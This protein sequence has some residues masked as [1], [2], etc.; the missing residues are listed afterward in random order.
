MMNFWLNDGL[1]NELAAHAIRESP[2]EVCGL[3]AGH[4][5]G[6]AARIIPIPNAAADPRHYFELDHAAFIQAMFAIERSNLQLIGIYHS[7]PHSDPIPSQTDIR[8]AHYPDVVTLIVSL[9]AESPRFA[10]WQIRANQVD[11]VPLVI[12]PIAPP[13]PTPEWPQSHRW[14]IVISAILAVV[15]L[16]VV[17]LSLLPPA[18]IIP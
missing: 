11:A 15:L 13:A 12:G 10:A 1:A 8:Q 2:H 5:S 14:A 17:S 18:P 16:I 3:I 4:E 7:H 9:A 6:R